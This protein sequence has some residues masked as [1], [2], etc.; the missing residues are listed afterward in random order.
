MYIRRPICKRTSDAKVR[1]IRDIAAFSSRKENMDNKERASSDGITLLS[2]AP[3]WSERLPL[4]L[5]APAPPRAGWATTVVAVARAA[6]TKAAAEKGAVVA[7]VKRRGWRKRVKNYQ[8]GS[9]EKLP[10]FVPHPD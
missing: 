2:E 3:V 1:T 5:A 10:E 6:L 9:P 4:P 7:D 8:T